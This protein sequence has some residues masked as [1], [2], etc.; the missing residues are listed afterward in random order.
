MEI[1]AN[2]YNNEKIF[3][4]FYRKKAKKC[5]LG[6]DFVSDFWYNYMRLLRT[7]SSEQKAK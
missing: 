3:L 5:A 1:K 7:P 2:I 6:V 4:D